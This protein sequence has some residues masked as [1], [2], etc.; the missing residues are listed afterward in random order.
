MSCPICDKKKDCKHENVKYCDHCDKVYCEDCGKSWSNEYFY[1]AYST[2]KPLEG[3]NWGYDATGKR[4]YSKSEHSP[5]TDLMSEKQNQESWDTSPLN[6]ATWTV[7]CDGEKVPFYDYLKNGDS[8]QNWDVT[9]PSQPEFD[10][11]GTLVSAWVD[12]E[13]VPLK[14]L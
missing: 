12:G 4:L 7:L 8:K 10:E 2:P 5:R 3:V 14:N 11:S 9:I 6:P 1:W 13:W